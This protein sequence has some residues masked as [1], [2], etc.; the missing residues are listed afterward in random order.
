MNATTDTLDAGMTITN[1][2][3]LTAEQMTEWDAAAV[4][5][6]KRHLWNH[7][8]IGMPLPIGLSLETMFA[9]EANLS[10]FRNDILVAMA[11]RCG[12]TAE[13]R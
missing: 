12:S 3:T 6:A 13:G 2:H 7:V 10:G 4:W 5:C 1:I 9:I 11:S 8:K